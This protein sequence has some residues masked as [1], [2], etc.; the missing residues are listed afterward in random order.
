LHRTAAGGALAS[1]P[2]GDLL[3]VYVNNGSESK[4]D[5]YVGR[6]VSYGV[7]LGGDLEAF[8]TTA[9][10]LENDAP[11]EGKPTIVIG[12]NGD[13]AKA[14]GDEVHV[15]STW[16]PA[17]CPLVSAKR[18]GEEIRV[19]LGLEAGHRFY[20]DFDRLPAGSSS[21]FITT[22]KRD[23]VWDGDLSSGTYRLT[24]LPQTTIQ[25]TTFRVRIQAPEGTEIVWTNEPMAVTGGVAVWSGAPEAPVTLE[26]RFQA[27][28]PL[29][30]IRNVTELLR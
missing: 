12:P 13:Q 30:W 10:T 19:Q 8:G 1:P 11:T 24:I 25:P 6:T 5:F 26:V 22:T 4:V 9:V 28:F 29:R 23:G 27:P 17:R 20:Y 7:R 15:L 3:A 2:G 14:P 16:C 21:T 18:D